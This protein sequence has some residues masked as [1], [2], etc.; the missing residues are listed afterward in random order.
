MEDK[1]VI[2]GDIIKSRKNFKPEKWDLFS[3][4]IDKV[5][6]RYREEME[7]PFSIYSGDSFGAVIYKLKSAFKIILGIQEQLQ[8]F[9]TRMVLVE[10]EISYGLESKSFFKLEGPALWNTDKELKKI[11]RGDQNFTSSL[12]DEQMNL[13]INTVVNLMLAMRSDWSELQWKVSHYVREGLTQEEIA[14]QLNITQQYVS[15][16]KRNSQCKLLHKAEK[17]I[18]DL[19][20]VH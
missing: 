9:K 17:N 6:E 18:L 4:A 10:G 5:N 15:K 14:Q 7:I 2:V 16:I 20:D 3:Q 19:L 12:K 1:Y 11:K 8:D 13:I